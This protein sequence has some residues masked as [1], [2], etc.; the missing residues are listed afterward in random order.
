MTRGPGN[1]LNLSAGNHLGPQRPGELH[2]LPD[3]V[4]V[5]SGQNP[6]YGC[7]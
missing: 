3:K 5:E 6:R 2:E 1:G 4:L 7:P